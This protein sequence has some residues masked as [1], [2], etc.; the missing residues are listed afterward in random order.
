[1][2]D[3]SLRI[4]PRVFIDNFGQDISSQKSKSFQ[5]RQ[6][7]TSSNVR[8]SSVRDSG[9]WISINIG[10]TKISDQGVK[11]ARDPFAFDEVRAEPPVDPFAFDD[12]SAGPPADPFAFEED[13]VGPTKWEMLAK[14]KDPTVDSELENPGS[15]SYSA[16]DGS[17]VLEESLLTAV[18]VGSFI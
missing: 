8:I 3:V 1:M 12:V 10:K 9:G 18:K 5:K 15:Y 14:R 13:D 17:T 4:Y 11:S 7:L 2:A 6:K 16:D